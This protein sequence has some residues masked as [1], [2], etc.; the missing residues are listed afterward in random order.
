MR[1]TMTQ[2]SLRVRAGWF[3]SSLDAWRNFAS[4]AIQ[5][6]PSVE[7]ELTAQADMNFRWVHM[8]EGTFSD[9]VAHL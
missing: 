1:P 9:G 6:A 7:S 8:R 5:N 4:L 3:E 2:I